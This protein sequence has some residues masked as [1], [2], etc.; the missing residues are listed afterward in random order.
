MHPHGNDMLYGEIHPSTIFPKRNATF[1]F[2]FI[3]ILSVDALTAAADELY[4]L[5]AYIYFIE[6]WLSGFKQ[7]DVYL[8][9]DACKRQEAIFR[10]QINSFRE[11]SCLGRIQAL[12]TSQEQHDMIRF[13]DIVFIISLPEVLS[14][15]TTCIIHECFLLEKADSKRSRLKILCCLRFII[16][17]F[18]IFGRV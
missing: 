13:H 5:T 15:Y 9:M 6:N 3:F 12:N 2:A 17:I 10:F 4:T 11:G 14:V 18:N 16:G 8:E 1:H 7:S